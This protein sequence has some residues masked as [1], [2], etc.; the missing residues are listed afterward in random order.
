LIQIVFARWMGSVEYGEFVYVFTWIQVL[1]L[2]CG[3]GLTTGVLRFVPQ[4]SEAHEWGLLRGLIRRSRQ[5]TF[6]TGAIVTILGSLL[7]LLL[8]P[9]GINV[10]TFVFGLVGLPLFA[11]FT[12]QTEI[13]RSTQRIVWAYTPSM[14]LQPILFIGIAFLVLKVSGILTSITV[15][16][17]VALAILVVLWVQNW[18]IQRTLPDEVASNLA[19]YETKNWLRVSFPLLIIT[20]FSV[21]Q[22]Q[23]DILLVGSF[24]SPGEVGIYVA[25]TKTALFASFALIAVNA[26]AVPVIAS[27]YTRRDFLGLQRL[28]NY[29]TFYTFSASVII[30]LLILVFGRFILG[31]FGSEFKI[32]YLPLVTL[33]LG[34]VF[35]AS[36]GPVGALMI[37]TGHQK[38]AAKV[39]GF[40][41]I[42]DLILLRFLL[43][44]FG[45][46]GAAIATTVTM[47]L[48]NF[49]LSILVMKYVNVRSFLF[50]L[51]RN[52]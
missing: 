1:A 38:Q 5:L 36:A 11:L 30:G 24:L 41:L 21:I 46:L 34:Q 37:M 12:L 10:N 25:A 35:N 22:N 42:F 43:P 26:I 19:S 4:Y 8:Q 32:G 2:L 27:L 31:W 40:S 45:L 7:L 17:S 13:I 15:M 49:W 16:G 33:T 20:G 47:F 52:K 39:L 50:L 51:I 9:D 48:W 14:L 44:R 23:A 29:S 28:T 6:G 3:L 18:G